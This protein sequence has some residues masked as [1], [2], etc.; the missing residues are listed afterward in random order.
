MKN[1]KSK[2]YLLWFDGVFNHSTLTKHK[3]LSPASSFWKTNLILNLQK[4][5]VENIT[6]CCPIEQAWPLGKLMVNKKNYKSITGLKAYFFSYLNF[7]LIR[8]AF[9]FFIL[10]NKFQKYINSR[11]KLPKFVVTWSVQGP[12]DKEKPE[13]KLARLISKKHHIKW[14]CL[15]GEGVTPPGATHYMY[16]CWDAYLNCK[17]EKKYYLDGGIPDFLS[18]KNISNTKLNN[19]VFMYIGDL[20]IHGG[21][22]QLA[23]SFNQINN[24]N[25]ELLFC[26]KGHNK[27]LEKLADSNSRIKI[28]GYLN[29]KKLNQIATNAYAFVN[30]RPLNFEPNLLNFPSKLLY[31]FSFEKPVLSTISPGMSP[32]IINSV[33]PIWNT[34]IQG[35]KDPINALLSKSETE[36]KELCKIIKKIKKKKKWKSEVSKF[37]NWIEK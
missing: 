28:L 6:L 9:K 21:A 25:I 35:I 11:R 19:K 29:E 34:E 14:L 33:I 16:S 26:G 36:Y 18:D 20:G 23:E 15:I 10:K 1:I 30:P 31:Y 32:E 13:I 22:L 24:K 37:K 7:P 8:E 17:Y 27:D 12:N 3:S 2:Y 5:G 4:L